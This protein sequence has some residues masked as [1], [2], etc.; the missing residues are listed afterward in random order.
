M[1]FN[2]RHERGQALIILALA[3]IGLLGFAALAIDGGMVYSDRRM[4]QSAV[5]AAALAGAAKAAQSLDAQGIDYDA[6]TACNLAQITTAKEAAVNGAIYRADT[7]HFT[8]STPMTAEQGVETSCGIVSAG[9]YDDKYIDVKVR[10]TFT[11]PPAFVHLFIPGGV[12]NT[13][14]AV[15]RIRP[16]ANSVIGQGLVSLHHPYEN[17]NSGDGGMKF[18]SAEI[19]V[20]GGGVFSNSCLVVDGNTKVDADSIA[21]FESS[22]IANNADIDPDP[23]THAT[24]RVGP[25]G[26]PKPACDGSEPKTATN[27]SITPGNFSSIYVGNGSTVKMAG[28]LYCIDGQ[29]EIK[30]GG[31]IQLET[32][33]QGVT[34]YIKKGG[35]KGTGGTINLQAPL[36][37]S[38]GGTPG[39]VIYVD[40]DSG[41]DIEYTGNGG[42]DL[43]GTVYAPGSYVKIEGT[44][45]ITTQ[46]HAQIIADTI[47]VG[48][49]GVIQIFFD[50]DDNYKHAPLLELFR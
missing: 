49:G 31:T 10:V 13:V 5:D 25:Y 7:N 36:N 24:K 29:F 42:S 6:F 46:L 33:G 45:N 38:L 22:K 14:E 50:E 27:G 37:D 39:L 41:G 11:T 34:L 28:G 43:T 47:D 4:A 2:R 9:L 17:K 3:L 12:R 18:H 35:I 16:R 19:T 15:A 26:I 8:I 48:G 1:V 32:P 21:Y 30:N 20:E 23:P 44:N 40:P